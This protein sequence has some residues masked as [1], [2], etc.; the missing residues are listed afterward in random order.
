VA[1]KIALISSHPIQYNAPLF[2]L[3]AKEPD[4]ELL[5]FYTWGKES[6]GPK[7][8]PDFGKE[9]EWDIPLLEG[10][11]YTFL[12]NTSKDPGSHH[13]KG[14]INPSLN[15]EIQAWCPDVLWVWGWAFDSHLKALIYFKGKLPVWFRGDST[16][17]DE[18]KGFSFKKLARRIFLTWVYRHVDKV[19]YVGSHNKDYYKK[20]GLNES[21]LIYAPHAIDNHRFSDSNGEITKK[22]IEWRKNLGFQDDDIVLLFAGKFEPRK[23][24]F[25]LVDLMKAL[26]SNKVKLLMVGNGPLEHNLKKALST[27]NRVT[28]MD[29][30][31]Q[32]HMPILYRLSDF[33]I[34]PSLSDTWGLSINEALASGTKVIA[35]SFCGGAIDLIHNDND[36]GIVFNPKSD[37]F[38]VFDYINLTKNQRIFFEKKHSL[39]VGHSYDQII[40]C[41]KNVSRR[42]TS[43]SFSLLFILYF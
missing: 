33:Y 14:I 15:K 30:Q 27:N 31:N 5:V 36:N 13:F 37:L 22:A 2:A 7:Y 6:L 11:N 42:A 29:F 26:E 18:P 38:A 23:N 28:F 16:L 12:K 43:N 17:L 39:L 8:D 40:Q 32:S 10:Y 4:I 41:V 25:F 24:P 19:Y 21:Q 34:L 3:I 9:I 35:S 1:R 20:H